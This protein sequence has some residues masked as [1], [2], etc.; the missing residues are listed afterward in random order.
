MKR[1][2]LDLSEIIEKYRDQLDME[3]ES[4]G[5]KVTP[6][7]LAISVEL[8]HLMIQYE[9]ERHMVGGMRWKKAN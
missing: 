8:D 5:W 3:L 1:V 7:V 4:S 2:L 9:R 6:R